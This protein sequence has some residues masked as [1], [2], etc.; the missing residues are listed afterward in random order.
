MK[1]VFTFYFQMVISYFNFFF[2]YDFYQ[3]LYLDKYQKSSLWIQIMKFQ[4]LKLNIAYLF[5]Y[6]LHDNIHRINLKIDF[7][8]KYW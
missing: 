8:L 2:N 3:F 4:F 6:F 1:S 7:Y 5:I